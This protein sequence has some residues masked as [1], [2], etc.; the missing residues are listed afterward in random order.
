M[1]VILTTLEAEIRRTVVQSQPRQIVSEILSGKNPTQKRAGS[2]VLVA[3]ACNP[4]LLGGRDQED[5]SSMSQA[6][7]F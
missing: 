6:N 3:D 4:S 1:S 2:W 5:C 7:R